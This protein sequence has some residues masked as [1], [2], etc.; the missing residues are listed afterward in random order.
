MRAPGAPIW[1]WFAAAAAC[2][3]AQPAW[4]E[5]PVRIS[6]FDG[7]GDAARWTF[8]EGAEFPGA[9]GG[10]ASVRG[11]QGRARALAFSFPC[12][13][14]A[15]CGRY[16][17]AVAHL[18]APAPV[19]EAGALR[20]YLNAPAGV[21]LLVRLTD[22][23]N[24]T[25][26]IDVPKA[27]WDD[28]G[29]R[30]RRVVVPMSAWAQDAWGGREGAPFTGDLTALSI[31]VRNNGQP[32]RG[33]VS[34]DDVAVI[35]LADNTYALRRFAPLSSRLDQPAPAWGVALHEIDDPHALDL[36][37]D[38][39]FSFVRTDLYWNAVERNGAFRF[40]EY[41]AFLEEA[42]ARGLGALFILDY[43][44]NAHGGREGIESGAAL[45]AFEAYARAAARHFA[46]RNV[47][48][49]IWNEPDVE[50]RM[51]LPGSR[52]ADLIAAGVRGVHAA[53]PNAPIVTGG[54]SFFDPDYVATTL[55]ALQEKPEAARLNAF[56]MHY[57]RGGRPETA[58]ADDSSLASML[59]ARDQGRL[60]IWNTEWGYS[61][62]TMPDLPQGRGHARDARRRQA[63]FAVRAHLMAWTM[64]LPANVW[65]ELRD[66]GFDA[67]NNEHNHGLIDASD[68]PKP[69][70]A[71]VQTFIRMTRDKNLRGFVRDTPA[72][73]HIARFDSDDQ[74]VFVVWNEFAGGEVRLSTPSNMSAAYDMLG[75][76]INVER[77]D[78]VVVTEE[79]GPIYIVMER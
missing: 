32:M 29:D 21:D 78:E 52:F 14:G 65:Y 51:N 75:D 17:A 68:R 31:L 47:A 26:Q 42:D 34:F 76:T 16:V 18:R 27:N 39:G 56:G 24:R 41:D 57:Y 11:R 54:L 35:D 71:A 3:V 8:S 2:A 33:A 20:F 19:P 37:R 70:F 6:S 36:A 10:L 79:G 63:A 38:A 60:P 45:P 15:A 61:T 49:E 44:H 40:R 25:F 28:Q 55:D 58:Y 53:D 46:D 43:W 13:T 62:T 12:D 7:R 22:S 9:G 77:R 50:E 4:A 72:G 1:G 30:W 66:G 48:Y 23:Q 74:I 59:S 67:R 73:V 64:G 69:A 5:P